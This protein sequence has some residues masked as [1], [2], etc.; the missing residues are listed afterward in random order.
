MRRLTGPLRRTTAAWTT[1]RTDR[2][3]RSAQRDHDRLVRTTERDQARRE[4]LVHAAH[5]VRQHDA[6]THHSEVRSGR[7]ANGRTT[8]AT[9]RWSTVYARLVLLAPLA[10]AGWYQSHAIHD[11]LAANWIIAVA[12]TASWDGAGAY[13]AQLYLRALLRRD[14]T[15]ALRLGMLVYA[16][17][18]YALLTKELHG[19]QVWIA[20]AIGVSTVSGIYLWSRH[21]RDLYRDRLHALGLVDAQA[22]KMAALRWLLCPLETPAAFRFG[23]RFSRSRLGPE[24]VLVEYRSWRAA[25]KPRQWPPAS[26]DRGPV[27]RA[28]RQDQDHTDMDHRAP[29]VQVDQE[30]AHRDADQDQPAAVQR[31]TLARPTGR[32]KDKKSAPEPMVRTLLVEYRNRIPSR[33]D[34]IRAMRAKG[35]SGWSHAETVQA[36]INEARRRRAAGEEPNDQEESCVS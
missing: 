33:R 10:V 17:G 30:P 25:G 6:T 21:A 36:A 1:W 23:I 22:P 18:S 19:R 7:A 14:S 15:I 34:V 3:L 29:A 5:L 35:L 20:H 26:T 9:S 11:L 12:F 8:Q 31:T 28:D 32:T 13:L 16:G 27:N 4:A 24:T 2:A